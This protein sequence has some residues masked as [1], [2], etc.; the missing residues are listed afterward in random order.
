MDLAEYKA[1]VARIPHGKRVHTALYVYRGEGAKFGEALD[2]LLGGIV[3]RC[4]IAPEFN[5]V[6]FRTDELK[7]SFLSYPDFLSDGHPALQHA[8][9]VDLVTGKAR[10]T[11]YANNI[12]PPILH[13]KESFLPS[14]HPWRAQFKALT[15]AEEA[16][17]LY[18]HAATI[19]FKLN[20]EKLLQSKGLVITGHTVEKAEGGRRKAEVAGHLIPGPS[21]PTELVLTH[22][23]GCWTPYD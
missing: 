7:V 16:A 23:S 13:R 9:T 8:I 12:N 19:E 3:Q 14:E 10:H 21:P 18:D 5:V 2:L 20:W 11:D 6:K 22:K 4:G 1:L 17:G 15:R